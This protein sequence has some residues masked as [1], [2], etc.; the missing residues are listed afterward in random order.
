MLPCLA[1]ED[2]DAR[3]S[4]LAND[5]ADEV[6]PPE[7]SGRSGH[8]RGPHLAGQPNALEHLLRLVSSGLTS[9]AA[10]IGACV[11][12]IITGGSQEKLSAEELERVAVV[13]AMLRDKFDRDNPAH[14]VCA[15][16]LASKI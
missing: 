8:E 7:T 14:Q 13:R 10:T 15:L 3:Q 4:L 1:A 11:Q 6:H 16:L 9:A 2:S 5:S 12:W